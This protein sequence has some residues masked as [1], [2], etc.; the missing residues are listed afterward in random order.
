MNL[1]LQEL[2]QSDVL[3]TEAIEGNQSSGRWL[4]QQWC[5]SP[6]TLTPA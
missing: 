4:P 1:C 3:V 6:G 5:N 2:H